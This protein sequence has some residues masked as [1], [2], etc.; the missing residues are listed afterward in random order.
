MKKRASAEPVKSTVYAV[1][2]PRAVTQYDELR[3]FDEDGLLF[4]IDLA[5][6][7]GR[8]TPIWKR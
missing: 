2:P 4:Q 8:F 6:D 1:K 7:K 3:W 5:D